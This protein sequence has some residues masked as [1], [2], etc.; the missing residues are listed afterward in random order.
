MSRCFNI[1]LTEKY[2][3]LKSILRIHKTKYIIAFFKYT[4]G[5]N[6]LEKTHPN[7]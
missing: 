5:T 1:A 6:N 2:Y 7:P 3:W 4:S